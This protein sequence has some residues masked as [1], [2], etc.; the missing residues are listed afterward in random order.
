MQPLGMFGQQNPE[1]QQRAA[2]RG[3]NAAYQQCPGF[4]LSPLIEQQRYLLGHGDQ[5]Q[6]LRAHLL[7]ALLKCLQTLL[8]G[9]LVTL[10]PLQHGT[11]QFDMLRQLRMALRRCGT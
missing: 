3:L 6:Q 10:Y 1:G 9:S 5:P 11:L 7:R 4:I 2:R 8:A